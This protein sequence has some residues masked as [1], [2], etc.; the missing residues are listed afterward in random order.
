MENVFHQEL[1]DK[2]YLKEEGLTCTGN[3]ILKK[4]NKKY[5]YDDTNIECR[6]NKKIVKEKGKVEAICPVT[7]SFVFD[8]NYERLNNIA[9]NMTASIDK[10]KNVSTTHIVKKGYDLASAKNISF[11]MCNGECGIYQT[12]TRK[13]IPDKTYSFSVLLKANSGKTLK[14]GVGTTGLKQVTTTGNWQKIS[15]EFVTTAADDSRF[16]ILSTSGFQANEEIYINSVIVYEKSISSKNKLA[17]EPGVV[18]GDRLPTP[19]RD[20]Y[21]FVGW[22]TTPT[23]GNKITRNIVVPKAKNITY[24]AHW[25]R[26]NT[27]VNYLANGGSENM[28]SDTITYGNDYIIKNNTFTKT[29]Y[30]FKNWKDN[31]NNK[32]FSIW[33]QTPIT[34]V[35]DEDINLSAVWTKNKYIITFEPAGGSVSPSTKEVTYADAY[36]SLPIPTRGGYTFTGWYTATSGGTKIESATPVKITANQSYI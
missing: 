34:W 7:E 4:Q 32:D 26:K 17:F 27:K 22:Y 21:E 3:I 28:T 19:K 1:V 35:F 23:G 10:W 20:G 18:F 6:S 30:I 16:S 36:G 5:I 24:Y 29:G 33:E 9:T 14:V 11:A 15:G 13:L 25:T 31:D 12:L 2:N 8:D